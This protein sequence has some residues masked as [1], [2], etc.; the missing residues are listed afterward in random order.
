ML[1]DVLVLAASAAFEPLA[2]LAVAAQAMGKPVIA[3]DVGGLGETLMPAATGWLVE[4]DDP[5][6][7]ANALDL[8]LAMPEEARARLAVRARRFVTRNFSLEQMNEATLRVYRELLEG[9]AP[10]AWRIA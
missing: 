10:D 9:R 3:S 6:A 4:P 8:A 7:L 5:A 1:A 2:R